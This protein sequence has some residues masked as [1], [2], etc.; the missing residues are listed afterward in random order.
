M[1]GV[2]KKEVL[3]KAFSKFSKHH[4]SVAGM[5]PSTDATSTIPGSPQSNRLQGIEKPV[6]RQDEHELNR[7]IVKRH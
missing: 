7:Y 6:L 1:S 3:Y 5:G 4:K 2:N